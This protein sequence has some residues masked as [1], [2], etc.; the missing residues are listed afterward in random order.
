MN[1]CTH[2][3][4]SIAEFFALSTVKP[5]TIPP[6]MS[7]GP[8]VPSV[9]IDAMTMVL[10]PAISKATDGASSW[11]RPTS[12]CFL[13]IFVDDLRHFTY[14]LDEKLSVSHEKN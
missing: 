6:A 11:L 4:R 7:V 5:S 13:E 8:S 2:S 12:S 3:K 1:V 10:L 14:I 9:P